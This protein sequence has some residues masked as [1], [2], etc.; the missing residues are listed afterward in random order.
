MINR[1]LMGK[2]PI[3][4]GDGTQK[5]C[6][7]NVCD[8]LPCFRVMA[9]DPAV[10]GEAINIGPDEEFVTINELAEMIARNMPFDL[11]PIYEPDRPAEVRL[12]SCSAEKA[13][14]LLGYKTTKSLE[15][16]VIEMI[17]WIRAEGPKPC[18]YNL[19]IEIVTDITPKVWVE[20]KM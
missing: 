10:A 3:I 19:E 12:A 18:S 15:D 16:G 9:E 7:T 1:M 2:Q 11:K 4:Y 20:K 13:R 17:E 8:I 5:R 6:F 14:R